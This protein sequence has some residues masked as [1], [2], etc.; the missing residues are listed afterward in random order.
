MTNA[1]YPYE[2]KLP[3]KEYNI[4]VKPSQDYIRVLNYSLI[5]LELFRFRKK[6]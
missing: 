3:I 1:K 6:V 2:V 5:V 4:S